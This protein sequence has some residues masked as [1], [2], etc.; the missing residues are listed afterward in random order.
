M[1]TL[2]II[3]HR[4]ILFQTFHYSEGSGLEFYHKSFVF[5]LIDIS[6]GLTFPLIMQR[7]RAAYEA[8][9]LF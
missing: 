9:I 2:A 3:W 1:F 5:P 6:S 7:W 4:D 8:T